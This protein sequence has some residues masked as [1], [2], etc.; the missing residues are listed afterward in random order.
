MMEDLPTDNPLA[1]MGKE[2]LF[3]VCSFEFHGDEICDSSNKGDKAAQTIN[4]TCKIL[5]TWASNP[6]TTASFQ[7]SNGASPILGRVFSKAAGS[8]NK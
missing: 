7:I 3:R 5:V 8:E 6:P 4:W 2:H 1:Q